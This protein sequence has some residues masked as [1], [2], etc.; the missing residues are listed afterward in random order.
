MVEAWWFLNSDKVLG[1]GD[2][3]RVEIG[4]THT[5]ALDKYNLSLCRYGL[6]GSIRAI[7]AVKRAPL[8]AA[9]L[10]TDNKHSIGRYLYRVLL[11]GQMIVGSETVC[12][13]SRTYVS[14][15]VDVSNTLLDFSLSC[16]H[17]IV[18]KF[19]DGLDFGIAEKMYAAASNC[20]ERQYWYAVMMYNRAKASQGSLAFSENTLFATTAAILTL[21]ARNFEYQSNLLETMLHSALDK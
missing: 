16:I 1:Y 6:H 10:K 5:V 14:G 20:H 12:A 9:G 4:D 11:D 17:S 7:D 18:S 15:G 13:E 8:G 21:T 3:R 19:E 2:G